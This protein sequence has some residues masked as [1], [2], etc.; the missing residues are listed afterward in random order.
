MNIKFRGTFF[1][2]PISNLC[3]I[4]IVVGSVFAYTQEST[5]GNI[6]KITGE[7]GIILLNIWTIN[8]KY[9]KWM[10]PALIIFILGPLFFV[11]IGLYNTSPI[12]TLKYVFFFFW[13]LLMIICIAEIYQDNLN[14]LISI[15]YMTICMCMLV[16]YIE[17]RG[18]S[19]DIVAL[20]KSII[21]NQRYGGNITTARVSMG[22]VNVNQLG[23]FGSIISLFS[24]N[25]LMLKKKIII[26]FFLMLVSII[27]ITN[28]GS[29]TPIL[30]ILFFL[31]VYTAYKLNNIFIS[32]ITKK[33]VWLVLLSIYG[34]FIFMLYSGNIWSNSYQLA[35]KLLSFRISYSKQA[36]SIL[37]NSGNYY[38]GIGPMSSSYIQNTFTGNNFEIDSS[39]AY[40][41]VTIGKIGTICMYVF[42]FIL[43][44]FLD[45]KENIFV[46]SL[47]GFYM[48]YA[49]FENVLF[50]PNSALCIF[51]F[52]IVSA[53]VRHTQKVN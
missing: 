40:Y 32:N 16:L 34:V 18:L 23:L 37:Q 51:T 3:M 36:L 13:F 6:I 4:L 14:L 31:C 19:F 9:Y 10:S 53:F 25:Y 11:S 20:I 41:L 17:Y 45:K 35:D 50:T 30:A 39:I 49:I 12:E 15:I 26:N 28:S 5:I 21:T 52:G 46:L 27:L 29:R 22:F 1:N 38:I 44:Y 8:F 33:M 47:F 7:F 43:G 42:L 2:N 48:I 24:I